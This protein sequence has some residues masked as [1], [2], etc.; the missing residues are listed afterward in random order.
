MA[1]QIETRGQLQDFLDVL[2]KRAWQV[3]LPAGFVIALGVSFAVV[4]PKKFVARTQLELRPV[5]ISVSSK[6]GAN[7]PFQVKAPARVTKVVEVLRN[8]EYLSLPPDEK[9]EFI[10]DTR[11]NVKV[12]LGKGTDQGSNFVTIEFAAV[13]RVWAELFLKRLRDDWVEDVL[14]RDRNKVEAERSMLQEQRDEL[15][16]QYSKEEGELAE[17][18]LRHGISATQPIP[19]ATG[20]RTE[21]P[22]YD[23]LQK[24]KQQLQDTDVNLARANARKTQYETLLKLTPEQQS[25][26]EL[27]AGK[28]NADE[29]AGVEREILE[30]EKELRKYRPQHSK[31]PSIK[32]DLDLLQLKRD[33]MERILERGGLLVVNT[34]NPARAE[35]RKRIDVVVGEI[36]ELEATKTRLETDIKASETTVG[37]LHDVYRKI[38]EKDEK[39]T[40]LK[41]ALQDHELRYRAK[42]LLAQDLSGPLANPFSII[43]E[44]H[45]PRQPTEPNPWIIVAFALV[46]GLALGVAI[47]VGLEYSRNCFR[48]VYDISRVM[49]VP[50]L[51][52]VN[53]IVT[54]RESRL[55]LLRRWLVGASSALLIGSLVFVTWAWAR[56][57]DLLSP[58][59][60]DTIEE[61]RS[62]LK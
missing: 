41:T 19:G 40:R 2:R 42:I 11:D 22:E 10:D 31:Y 28:S 13:D 51:G 59:L 26:E 54:R 47:A 37:G 20:Q 44:V 24:A 57:P 53:T 7:A 3:I 34:V 45:V 58:G 33:G 18:K 55:R 15:Q 6:E 46:A 23:R 62:Q 52:S 25:R 29:L 30:K 43:E 8:P 27:V 38:R 56:S 4:V 14:E 32:N 5:G 1:V 36:G 49:V 12:V 60:R 48:S 61:L 39:I 50:V 9:K 21:D 16:K 17:L 35:M